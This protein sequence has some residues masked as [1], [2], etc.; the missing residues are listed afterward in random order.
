MQAIDN[1]TDVIAGH[2]SRRPCHPAGTDQS[3]AWSG[4]RHASGGR[5]S[6]TEDS[7][8][9]RLRGRGDLPP[10]PAATRWSGL[11]RSCLV[12]VGLLVACG[13]PPDP[14]SDSS[15]AAAVVRGF[16]AFPGASWDG[17]I[18]TQE[19]DGQL[20]WVVSWTAPPAESEVRRFFMRTLNGFGWQVGHGDSAHELTLRRSDLPIRGYLR[21]GRPELGK[22][23][24]GVTLGI[25]DPRPHKNGCLTA[26]PSLPVYPGA[27]ARQCNLVHT[28]GAR[29]F[30]LQA[31]TSDET[32]L[33]D[34]TLGRVLLDA[35]WTTEP[36][37]LG[38]LVF[39]QQDGARETARVMWGPDP[40]GLRP[41]AFMLS[42]DLPEASLSELPQ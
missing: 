41:T 42:I 34:R 14:P 18:T 38:V 21:F 36:P 24:T 17:D 26:L 10:G 35:G 15:S 39:R 29:S 3:G 20:T 25:R 7:A 8:P 37:V 5:L 4:P 23:G 16:P 30:T 11:W 40:L 1:S 9:A 27:E 6:R 22:M 12:L 32:D 13:A 2:S 28:P 19:A 33:A 31:A